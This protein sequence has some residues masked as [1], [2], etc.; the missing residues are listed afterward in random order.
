MHLWLADLQKKVSGNLTLSRN[1]E[2]GFFI[3]KADST[4]SVKGMLLAT[5]YKGF[6]G[7]CIFQK[8]TAEFDPVT[9]ESSAGSSSVSP[10]TM[11][12]PTSITLRQI[13]EEFQAVV[14][15]I[16]ESIGEIIGVDSSN[17]STQDPRFCVA[18]DS[19]KG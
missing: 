10:S 2:K 16:A 18:L 9:F 5:P 8:W 19:S 7:L 3:I 13:P 17:D 14:R 15:E 12:I 6:K 1:L 4:E 11:K